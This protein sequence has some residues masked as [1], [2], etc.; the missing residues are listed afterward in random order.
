[1]DQ[2]NQTKLKMDQNPMG[3]DVI[4]LAMSNYKK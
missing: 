1:M 2:G 3:D 4:A